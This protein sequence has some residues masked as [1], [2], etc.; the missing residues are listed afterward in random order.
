MIVDHQS[1]SNWYSSTCNIT[2]CDDGS[3]SSICC[4]RTTSVTE[5]LKIVQSLE[6]ET[7]R[8]NGSDRRMELSLTTILKKVSTSSKIAG[9]AATSACKVLFDVSSSFSV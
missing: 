4:T 1:T 2:I 5:L 8:S 6:L 7:L 9:R 3:G